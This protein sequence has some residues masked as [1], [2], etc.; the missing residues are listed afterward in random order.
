MG[1]LAFYSDAFLAELTWHP[2][3]VMLYLFQL[4]LPGLKKISIKFPV[5][6]KSIGT[7][8]SEIKYPPINTC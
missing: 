2:Y 3:V 4:N 7:Q 6:Q 5:F 8:K 1:P